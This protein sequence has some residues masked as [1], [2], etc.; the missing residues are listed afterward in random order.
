MRFLRSAYEQSARHDVAHPGG[1]CH[2]ARL[3]ALGATRFARFEPDWRSLG[4]IVM[5]D[6]EGNEFCLD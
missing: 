1:S 3:R 6:P 2:P 5:Q 4:F